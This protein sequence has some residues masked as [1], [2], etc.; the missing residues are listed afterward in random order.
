MLSRPDPTFYPSPR[1]AMDAPRERVAYVTAPNAEAVLGRPNALRDG[2]A[3]IDLDPSSS[4]Y[5]QIIEMTEVPNF[6]DELHHSGWN[7]CSAALC[8]YAP[9]PHVERRYL[10]LPALRS[11]R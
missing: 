8:P 7:A 11:S 4:T 10:L 3:T 5:G 2:L 6:G 1:M 9:H